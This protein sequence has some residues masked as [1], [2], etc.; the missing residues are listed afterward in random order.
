MVL[1]SLPPPAPTLRYP[2]GG[3]SGKAGVDGE[4]GGYSCTCPPYSLVLRQSK[5]VPTQEIS[6][7]LKVKMCFAP[8]NNKWS[9]QTGPSVGVPIASRPLALQYR[10]A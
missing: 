8:C 6:A 7:F 9:L 2:K 4:R 1:F 3:G 5:A 10:D